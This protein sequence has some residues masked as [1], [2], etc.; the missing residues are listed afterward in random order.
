MPI[1]LTSE[2][3]RSAEAPPISTPT[4]ILL[5]AIHVPLSHELDLGDEVHAEAGLHLGL[6]PAHE[7]ADVGRARVT[8]VDDEVR[9]LPAHDRVADPGTLQAGG[10]DE[11]PG[12]VARRIAED[13]ARVRLRQ[14]LLRDPFV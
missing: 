1:P 9:V 11:P 14:R 3:C 5:F 12:V 2:I 4:R 10:L 13:R 6:A 7:R 8:G